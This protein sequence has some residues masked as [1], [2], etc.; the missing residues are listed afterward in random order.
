MLGRFIF[1]HLT[2]IH[3]HIGAT[4]LFLHC[5]FIEI[6]SRAYVTDATVAITISVSLFIFPSRR[7]NFLCFKRNSGMCSCDKSMFL[8][9]QV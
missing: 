9:V 6:S 1:I 2:R 4:E 3:V 8:I 7:P 5:H